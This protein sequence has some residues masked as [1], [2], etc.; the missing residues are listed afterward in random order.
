MASVIEKLNG[1]KFFMQLWPFTQWVT[2]SV[3]LSSVANGCYLLQLIGLFVLVLI[4][5]YFLGSN[6]RTNVQ[7]WFELRIFNGLKR[8][9]P[10][11]VWFK[12]KSAMIMFTCQQYDSDPEGVSV[13][14]ARLI[15]RTIWVDKNLCEV[16]RINS[17]D[18]LICIKVQKLRT[19]LI[20][21]WKLLEKV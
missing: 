13:S 15:V 2:R 10:E 7:Y 3:F 5:L 1:C 8:N 14:R 21:C 4:N 11:L 17:K 16:V 12:K 20:H 6:E 9:W 18:S 19:A